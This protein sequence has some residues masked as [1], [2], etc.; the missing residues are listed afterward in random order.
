LPASSPRASSF[1]FTGRDGLAEGGQRDLTMAVCLIVA[2]AF[3]FVAMRRD[4]P[5]AAAAFGLF[6]GVA[7]TIKPHRDPP[8][9]CTVTACCM[10]AA[11]ISH[12]AAADPQSL[13]SPARSPQA[14]RVWLHP[15]SASSFCCESGRSPHS[16]RASTA[17]S[18]TTPALGTSPAP[19]YSAAQHLASA[20]T[21]SDL[22]RVFGAGRIVFPPAA[23]R[24][25]ESP[26]N[27]ETD[28][29][30]GGCS[31]RPH[32]LRGARAPR[33]ALLSLPAAGLPVAA[34][35]RGTSPAPRSLWR[36]SPGQ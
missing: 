35:G 17:S 21:G 5:W 7:L 1:W 32:Q 19:L 30:A 8:E 11:K 24:E 31:L 36:Q 20:S 29:P 4:W 25:G 3:L 18:P 33:S 22:D 13:R 6:S 23:Q 12:R 28:R 9:S 2:T 26:R 27:W 10:G 14:S 15:R 34:D 16:S